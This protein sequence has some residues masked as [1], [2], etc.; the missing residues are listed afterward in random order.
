MEEARALYKSGMEK[1]YEARNKYRGLIDGRKEKETALLELIR[2]DK[3]DVNVLK[4]LIET[5]QQLSVKLKY[6]KRG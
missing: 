6:I 3:A 1:T 5:A 4:A 2:Q